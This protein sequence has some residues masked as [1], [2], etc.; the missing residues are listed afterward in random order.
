MKAKDLLKLLQDNPTLELT[1]SEYTGCMHTT[2]KVIPV[3]YNVGDIFNS[4]DIADELK[5]FVKNK[6]V[7]K[8]FIHFED[9]K[10]R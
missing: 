10:Y 3:V 7:I 6:K 5:T 9:P 1:A 8:A 2:R 4:E